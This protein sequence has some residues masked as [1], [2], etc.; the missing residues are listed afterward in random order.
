[1]RDERGVVLLEALVA[2]AI[3]GTAGV[4]LVG[5][6]RAAVEAQRRAAETEVTLAA[7][8][9]LLTATTL[10]RRQELDQ[11]LGDHAV[12]EFVVHIQRPEPALYRLAIAEVNAPET[13]MLVTVVYRP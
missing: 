1:M 10:L 7:A 5:L 4:A 11:R 6:G 3:L 12:G 9:R 8:D 13:E 2:L